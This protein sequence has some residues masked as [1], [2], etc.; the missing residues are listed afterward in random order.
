[1]Q[2][3]TWGDGFGYLL[4]ATGRMDAMVDPTVEPYDIAPMPVVLA[5]AGGRFTDLHGAEGYR[6][7]SGVAT[8]GALHDDVLA[9]LDGRRRAPRPA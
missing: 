6:G 8:N 9:V 1:M 7:G 5:E 4:V 3:R 2:L